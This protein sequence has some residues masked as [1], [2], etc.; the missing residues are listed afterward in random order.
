MQLQ[1][2]SK[3]SQK[4]NFTTINKPSKQIQIVVL[5][6]KFPKIDFRFPLRRDNGR[7]RCKVYVVPGTKLNLYIVNFHGHLLTESRLVDLDQVKY[8]L[9]EANWL[10][11]S[12]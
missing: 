7:I 3:L 4:L 8:K 9:G 5:C 10:L 12:I 2:L 6:Q 1:H 11:G